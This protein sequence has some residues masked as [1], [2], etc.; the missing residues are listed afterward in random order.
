MRSAEIA[1]GS[2]RNFHSVTAEVQ[3]GGMGGHQLKVDQG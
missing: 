3:G 1:L 2:F